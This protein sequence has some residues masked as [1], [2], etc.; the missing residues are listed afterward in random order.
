MDFSVYSMVLANAVKFKF[1]ERGIMFSMLLRWMS[2]SGIHRMSD[3]T[4]NCN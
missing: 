1:S 4:L 3:A 2:A